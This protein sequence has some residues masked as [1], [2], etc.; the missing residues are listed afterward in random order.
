MSTPGAPGAPRRLWPYLVPLVVVVLA[1]LSTVWLPFVNTATLWFGLP[2]VGVWSVVW[3]LAIVPALAVLE[4][5]GRYAEVD[6]R[7]EAES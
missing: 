2:S 3:V 1:L 4:F 6:A 5:S 7:E